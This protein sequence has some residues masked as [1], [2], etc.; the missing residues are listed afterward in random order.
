MQVIEKLLVLKA[1]AEKDFSQV[2]SP[3]AL[4]NLRIKYLGKKGVL[5]EISRRIPSLPAEEKPEVGRALNDLKNFIQSQLTSAA[6]HLQTG[7][8]TDRVDV[9]QPGLKAE[10]GHLH[11]ISIITYRL[12]DI[13]RTMG[14]EVAFGPE[15]ELEYYNFDALNFP[16]DHPSRDGYDTFYLS[17]ELLL[18]SHTSPVQVRVME[19]RK[20]PLRIVA[21]GRVYRPDTPDASHYPV[22][23]QLEGLAVDTNISF[24]DLKFVLSSAMKE[25]YGEQTRTR[26]RPSFFP[27]TEPSAEVDVSCTICSGDGCSSCGY[28]GWVELLGAGMVHPSVFRAVG[29]DPEKYTGFAFGMGID[30][31]AMQWY[32]IRDIRLLF[33]NDLRILRQF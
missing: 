25:L 20:P 31:I 15:I 16:P 2:S 11:P 14:F 24:A 32:G 29:Y 17:D 8:K 3:E 28:K 13:F 4:E 27:F 9:T 1:Q 30:R 12:I 21:P 26:F 18:R 23:H 7:V 19:K 5:R 22:F 6:R 10:L 33:E